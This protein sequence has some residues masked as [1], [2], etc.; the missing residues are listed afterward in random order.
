MLDE[1][2]RCI[3]CR[4]IAKMSYEHIWGEWT[5]DHIPRKANK[6]HAVQVRIRDIG[7]QEESVSRIRAGD[8][9]D[10]TVPVVCELC[11]NTWMSAIQNRAKP[12][13]VPL[14]EGHYDLDGTAQ[15]MVSAWI[16]MAT[17][18]GEFSS[19]PH[20]IVGVTQ[21]ERTWFK[22][23]QTPPRNWGIWIGHRRMTSSEMQWFHAAFPIS[24]PENIPEVADDGFAQ[25]NS[26]ST[27]FTIG[28]LFILSI[29]TP[30]PEIVGGWRWQNFRSA[31]ARLHQIWPIQS[32][33]IWGAPLLIMDAEAKRIGTAFVRYMEDVAKRDR[34]R[35]SG[36]R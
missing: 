18:T 32:L 14:F 27:A 10:A 22:D 7:E 20:R 11:N 8:P 30:F 17:M 35:K 24:D 34:T 1:P 26:Q 6:H 23:T 36:S 31:R 25:A 5:K 33:A 28:D 29:S 21:S 19:K 12:F 15:A 2:Q 13:L 3:F 16:A 4:S 9:L